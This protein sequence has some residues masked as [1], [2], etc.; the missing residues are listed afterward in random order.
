M[1][2]GRR[3]CLMIFERWPPSNFVTYWKEKPS[4]M[5][6]DYKDGSFSHCDFYLIF[7]YLHGISLWTGNSFLQSDPFPPSLFFHRWCQWSVWLQGK[8]LEEC[9]EYWG[10]AQSLPVPSEGQPSHL[11]CTCSPGSLDGWTLGCLKL[12][13]IVLKVSMY[14]YFLP[15]K[16]FLAFYQRSLWLAF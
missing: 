5:S 4:K 9:Q 12:P 11:V 14:V 2:G 10:L 3:A 8:D 16:C 13:G 15:G 7:S 1:E 6:R